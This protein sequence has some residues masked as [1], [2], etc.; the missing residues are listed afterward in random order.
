[1]C[2][3]IRSKWSC[4]LLVK[5]AGLAAIALLVAAA[6]P[7]IRLFREHEKES[8]VEAIFAKAQQVACQY[9]GRAGAWPCSAGDLNAPE[10]LV[11]ILQR[12]WRLDCDCRANTITLIY[13][14]N[15]QNYY[16]EFNHNSGSIR[17]GFVQHT[18]K[19]EKT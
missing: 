7:Q 11:N 19:P 6:V 14:L 17:E 4:G 3:E 18:A 9:Y 8:E 1:M 15:G 5:L 13:P 12:H 2:T 16:K 10:L